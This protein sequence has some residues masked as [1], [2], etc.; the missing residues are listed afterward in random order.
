MRPYLESSLDTA[1]SGELHH[2][3]KLFLLLCTCFK[4]NF[5]MDI[6]EVQLN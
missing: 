1:R 3:L 2:K 4:V 5:N 6:L